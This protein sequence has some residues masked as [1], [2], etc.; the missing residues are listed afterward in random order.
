M[1]ANTMVSS[2]ILVSLLT[3]LFA[4]TFAFGQGTTGTISGTVSD[5][6]GAV[7]SGAAVKVVNLATNLTR[8]TTTSGDGYFS[9]TL[10]PP[11]RYSVEVTSSS[12][13][14]FKANADVSITQTTTVDAQLSISSETATVEVRTPEVQAETSQ[15]GRT[16]TGDTIRQL[17]LPTRNFQQLLA[18][19]PGAQSSV[20]NSTELGRGDA[21]ISVNGQRTTSNSVRI[22][23]IDANSIGTNSTPNLAVPATDS[24]QEFIVQTSLYDASNGRSAGGNIEAITRSGTNDLHG[25]L[26]YFL[27]NK[28]L[29]AND[30]FLKAR[31]LEKPIAT[32][33][34][35]GGTVGGPVVHDRVFFF[36]SYQ[37]T[38]ERNGVSLVNS[39]TSPL[40]PSGLRDDNRTPAGLAATFGIPVASISPVA[41]AILNARLANGAYAIPSSGVTSAGSPSIA[42][43]VPQSGISRFRENQ[44]NIN[45]DF[46]ITNKNTLAAKF[47]VADN[48]TFQAN[49]NF[50]GL[51][52]GE[53]Q[54]IGFGGDL[55]IQQKLYSIT[56]THVFSST[57]INQLRY[58]FNRLLVTSVPEEPFTAASLGISS[59]LGSLFAGAPTIR[60]QG[61]DAN[62]FFG[63]GTLADQSSRISAHTINDTISLTRGNHRIR[64]GAE[65]RASTVK[66]YFNAFSRG[67]ILFPSFNAFL[68]GGSPATTL[69][70]IGSGVFDRS[71]KVKDTNFFVQD[72]WK[73]TS[74]LTLNLGLRYDYYGLPI[75]AQGR[76]VNFL[77]DQAIVGSTGSPSSGSNGFVQAAGGPLVGVPTVS[78][79]LVP[80]DK[81][82]FA[83]RVGFAYAVDKRQNVVIRGGYGIYYDRI[84]TRFA[85]TQLF[86]YP[87]FSLGVGLPGFTT[88]FANPFV[89]IPLPSSF[90]TAATIPSPLSPIAPFVGVPIA[91]VYVDPKLETPYV[92]QYNIGVQWQF[93]RGFVADVGY[94]GN[95]G[96]HLLQLVTLNQPVYSSATNAFTTRFPTAIISGNK[97]A[98][99]GVQQVQTTSL[100]S[101]N[102][103]QASLSKRFS[104]GL[105]FLA[106]YTR[107]KAIDYYS[108]AALNE[109]TNIPGD[110]VNWKTNRG[111]SDFNRENRFVLSGVYA[112]PKH[113]YGSSFASGLLNNWQIA[114]ITVFQSGLPFSIINSNDTSIISRANYNPNYR[115]DIYTTGSLSTRTQGYFNTAAFVTSCV[116]AACSAAVGTVTNPNFDP[117]NPFGNTTRNAYTGPGQKNVDI[118]FIKLVPITERYRGEFRVELFNAFNWV[119]YANPN[120]NLAAANL[121]RIERTSTGP[122]VIQ[123]AFKLN[124]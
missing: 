108:G 78:K 56:D 122:R 119:N 111:R 105:Q 94:V 81:N 16:I 64:I 83:P 45:G 59:P 92:E 102:S 22:N 5:P 36:G 84:S 17:P 72:D 57:F 11:G 109:L 38:R 49:Y 74:R 33:N 24:I 104:G 50:A 76:L 3:I 93:G 117:A 103:F 98:T 10:L 75:E 48:P 91:G 14:P 20:T 2:K 41:V 54:L 1:E 86:N 70:L 60:V 51:G 120:N 96:K 89:N 106:A 30:P 55:K 58:G 8:E 43:L 68:T 90:P 97:N 32:R 37:G 13:R 67:Q 115:G 69:S 77:P 118:S 23:G 46:N 31:G 25:N 21:T 71:F 123:L 26:Y 110:Q 87:Y 47:F 52:N 79:T 112:I 44:F 15:N 12:F 113:S 100:S 66:F 39:L 27:R 107:G 121:G 4:A 63:S 99:G 116:N 40:I 73:V 88:T 35:F 6:N 29:N 28:N 7:V 34:Q 85:N 95:R 18:L 65:Y 124:F 19:S 101:Y 114:T 42:T 62:F 53:R 61:A 80:T 82:N 9:V